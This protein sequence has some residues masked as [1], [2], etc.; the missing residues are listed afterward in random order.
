MKNNHHRTNSFLSFLILFFSGCEDHKL[1]QPREE[2]YENSS[3]KDSIREESLIDREFARDLAREFGREF[4]REL[5]LQLTEGNH[6]IAYSTLK[7]SGSAGQDLRTEDLTDADG[8]PH[9]L[10][11]H[12]SEDVLEFYCKNPDAF[13]IERL[14]SVPEGLVWE[15]GSSELEFASSEAKKGGTWNVFMSDFPRTL[16]TIGPDANGAFRSYLLDYNAMSLVMTHPN[17]DGYFPGLARSWAVSKD[18]KTVYFKLDQNAR[19]SDG[20]PVRASDFFFTFYFMRS[21]HV[22]APWYNDYYG[23]DKFPK[24]TLYDEKTISITFYK[25]KPDVVE[26]VSIRPIPE[27]FY[28]ELDGEFLKKY[29]WNPEPT[30][31]PYVALP[32]NVDKGKSIVLI[33]QRDWWADQKRFYRYRF[34]PD[35]IRVSVVRDYNKAFEIFLKGGIDMFGLAKT[36]FWYE[37]IPDD[38]PLVTNGYLSKVTFFNQVPPPSFALRINSQKAPLDNK[39]LRIGFHHAMNFDLILKKIFRDDYIRMNTVADGYGDRSHPTLRARE[40]SVEKAVE[41]FSKAG[42]SKR[43]PDGILINENGERLTLELLTGYKP[44]EDV[45]VV[46]KEEAKKAGLELKLKILEQTAAWKTAGEKNHQVVFSAFNSS[47]EL[48]PRFWEPYH[49][50]NAFKEVGDLKYESDGKLKPDLTTKPSTN[51]LTQTAVK[52]I[53]HLIDLYRPEEE[54][55]NI[56]DMAHRLAEMIHDHAVYVPAWKKPWLRLGHWNWIKFPEDWGP[57]ET[58]DYEEFQVFWI[59]EKEKS[60]ILQAME[61]GRSVSNKPTVRIYE[62]YKTH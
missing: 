60:E 33:R 15:D 28:V 3:S 19:Y 47:V 25:A 37:K 59:E 42:Y 29:Q 10:L 57:K 21:K 23:K 32:E 26:R 11:A 36:E 4:A 53:D 56:T 51:N 22:Q 41:H 54:L 58:R 31:G 38:H 27:H 9:P 5:A 24:V 12:C 48:F 13:S 46:L 14:G 2:R 1:K 39:D 40:F 34:N 35:R 30:T 6:S 43:G 44:Y 18:G 49:S 8:D 20:K 55:E 17:S 7:L 45:L 16:R 62:K 50:D 52:E 61:Q